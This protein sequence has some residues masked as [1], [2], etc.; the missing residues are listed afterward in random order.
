MSISAIEIYNLHQA[1]DVPYFGRLYFAN[2]NKVKK[3]Y[4]GK[5]ALVDDFFNFGIYFDLISP[6]MV[7][8]RKYPIKSE[9]SNALIMKTEKLMMNL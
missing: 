1:I 6:M 7:K 5:S 9:E 4:I 3:L 2:N 8:M